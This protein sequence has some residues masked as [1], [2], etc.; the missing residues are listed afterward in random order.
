MIYPDTTEPVSP[1]AAALAAFHPEPAPTMPPTNIMAVL[2]IAKVTPWMR[3]VIDEAE[4]SGDPFRVCAAVGTIARLWTLRDGGLPPQSLDVLLSLK[5]QCP[6][7]RCRAWFTSLPAAI[8]EHVHAIGSYTTDRIHDDGVELSSRSTPEDRAALHALIVDRDDAE[9]VSWMLRW[10]RFGNNLAG[11]LG[12]VDMR[13]PIES[14][15]RIAP[16]GFPADDRI[17]AVSWQEPEAWWGTFTR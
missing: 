9:S 2:G 7:S 5:V 14:F 3:V 10:T 16:D 15:R 11:Y 12:S 13:L 17:G 1:S 8:I 6:V 4:A